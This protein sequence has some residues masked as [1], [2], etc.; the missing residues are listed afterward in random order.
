[1]TNKRPDSGERVR[2]G[3]LNGA[4]ILVRCHI[5]LLR[6]LVLK[7]LASSGLGC[8]DNIGVDN[9]WVNGIGYF[10]WNSTGFVLMKWIFVKL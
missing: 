7:S 1:M 3:G 2:R 6:V 8:G 10:K 4:I 5:E 9:D